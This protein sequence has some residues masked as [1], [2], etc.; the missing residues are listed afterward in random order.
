MNS[1]RR[2]RHRLPPVGPVDAVVLPAERDAVV[3][4]RD[5]TAI[6]DGDAVGVAREIAQHLLGPGERVLG[7]DHPFALAQRRQEALERSSVG[8][9]RVVAEELQTAVARGP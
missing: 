5:Q 6:G 3:V 9:C 1:C 8:E 2:E 4:G 7:V